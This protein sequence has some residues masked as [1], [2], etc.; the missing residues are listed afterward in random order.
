MAHVL[1]LPLLPA[2]ATGPFARQATTPPARAPIH[3][4]RKGVGRGEF[5]L[6]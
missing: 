5:E 3:G 1:I 2:R 6:E 4:E